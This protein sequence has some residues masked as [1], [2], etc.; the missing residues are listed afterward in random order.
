MSDV[1]DTLTGQCLR[2]A[3]DLR[4]H[5]EHRHADRLTDA[6]CKRATT[7]GRLETLRDEGRDALDRLRLWGDL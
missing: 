5:D 3:R 1:R 2:L 7:I 6:A 4:R